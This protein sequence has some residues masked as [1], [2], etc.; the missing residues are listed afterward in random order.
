MSIC[1]TDNSRHTL[2][3]EGQVKPLA[4]SIKRACEILDIGHTKMWELIGAKRVK[5][6]SIGRKR[7]VIYSSLEALVTPSAEDE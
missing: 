6:I 3:V 5:T 4:V 2:S 7:L 1:S